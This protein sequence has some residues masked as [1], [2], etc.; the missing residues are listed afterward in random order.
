[1]SEAQPKPTPKPEPKPN[2][3]GLG[4][5]VETP[6]FFCPKCGRSGCPG[7]CEPPQSSPEKEE[8]E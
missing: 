7:N 6:Y 4:G 5:I 3:D 8:N 2:K 1:M